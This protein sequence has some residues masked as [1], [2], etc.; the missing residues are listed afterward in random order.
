MPEQRPIPLDQASSV[1]LAQFLRLLTHRDPGGAIHRPQGEGNSHWNRVVPPA[2]RSHCRESDARSRRGR[3]AHR[4]R[5]WPDPRLELKD[6]IVGYRHHSGL[7]AW[8]A[9]A[10]TRGYVCEQCRVLPLPHLVC[11]QCQEMRRSQLKYS[12]R[13]REARPKTRRSFYV[14]LW[15]RPI[16]ELLSCVFAAL[17]RHAQCL[18]R[19]ASRRRCSP[20]LKPC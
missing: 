17:L 19:S 12:A 10:P 5:H 16:G 8:L 3:R 7:S 2:T 14:S 6:R 18:H 4:P 11:F 1:L 9:Q 15:L 13:N 20:A